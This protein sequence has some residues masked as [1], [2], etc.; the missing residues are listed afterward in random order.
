MPAS[1]IMAAW[2]FSSNSPASGA[3]AACV[4]SS[5]LD[6]SSGLKGGKLGLNCHGWLTQAFEEI[7]LDSA[8]PV[9]EA[10]RSIKGSRPPD[11]LV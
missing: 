3:P 1:R 10:E 11:R 7:V 4:V 2:A 9:D 6:E 8:S 5:D